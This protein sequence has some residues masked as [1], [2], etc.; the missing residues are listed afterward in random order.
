MAELLRRSWV[1]IN[2]TQIQKN[3][4]IYQANI[5]PTA[6]VMAVVKADAYGHGDVEVARTLQQDGVN[7]WAVSNVEEACKL[8][9]NGIL[10]EILILGYT[11]IDFLGTVAENGI[12]QAIISEEYAEAV[13]KA[14]IKVKC[15]FA[16]DTGMN[17]I[18]LNADEP[19]KCIKIIRDFAEFNNVDGIFTHL[20]V[21]DSS[22]KNCKE[23]TK[24]QIGKFEAIADG[25][26][27]LN[28]NHI[29]CM[30]SAGG[31]WHTTKYNSIA[32]LGIILY[33]LK[34][35]YSNVLPIGIKPAL[36]WKSVISMVKSVNSGETI[37]YGCTFKTSKPMRI[38]TVPTGYADGYNRMLS[39]KG[40]VII[41]GETAPIVGRIC[42]DQFMIDVTDIPNVEM[43]TEVFLLSEKYNADDMAN[44]IGT[45]G[46]EVVCDISKRVP[47]LYVE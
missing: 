31:L 34:P 7:L 32:R 17:R 27:D 10:G 23:F 38:A 4:K 6:S 28:M 25:L 5:S 2:L 46:Y 35:D 45:I 41:N 19:E 18:G 1:E 43:G 47:R 3:F 9:D 14:N 26:T 13:L 8:R 36:Q 11:P 39:N 40:H 20:C 29:H 24:G 42:M 30:N 21:A 16:I 22:D 12:T 44:D 15:Q 33:G 37:G